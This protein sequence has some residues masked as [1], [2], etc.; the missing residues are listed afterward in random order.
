MA[1]K[2]NA[3]KVIGDFG[4]DISF[5]SCVAYQNKVFYGA[6]NTYQVYWLKIMKI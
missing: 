2:E 1:F 5:K 3:C 4:Q 6:K